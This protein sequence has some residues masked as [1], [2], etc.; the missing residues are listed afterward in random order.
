MSA[1][2]AFWRGRQ[3]WWYRQRIP[4]AHQLRRHLAYYVVKHGFEIGDYSIGLPTIRYWNDG[5]RLIVGRYSSVA[6]GATFV[7]GGQHNTS[8]ITAFP[9]GAALDD[10]GADELPHSRGDIVIGSDVWVAANATVLSGVTIGDGAVIGAGSVVIQDV[11]PYGIVFGSP[12]RVFQK[13]FSDS[14]IE[15]LLALRW[16]DFDQARIRTLR[17]LLYGTDVSAL[18]ERVEGDR[19][20]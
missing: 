8:R 1:L 4:R 12:A 9:L 19:T 13:R 6:A 10:M 17:P 11:P 15:T 2:S 18:V 14:D 7:V 5:S 20:T 16:W 3:Q